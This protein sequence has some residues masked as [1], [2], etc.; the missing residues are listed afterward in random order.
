MDRIF[1]YISLRRPRNFG[2]PRT[3][4]AFVCDRAKSRHR[5]T[6]EPR[7]Q[8]HRPP[9]AKNL[10]IGMTK[11]QALQNAQRQFIETKL[12]AKDSPNRAGGRR[13]IPGQPP[14][15]SLIHP[16]YWPPFILIGNSQSITIGVEY[17]LLFTIL[18]ARCTLRLTLCFSFRLWHFSTIT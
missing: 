16:H 18:F 3:Q 10:A 17:L 11:A 15:D 1:R 8:Q 4:R 14:V 9:H 12:T 5:L 13:S 7:R 2:N 6:L